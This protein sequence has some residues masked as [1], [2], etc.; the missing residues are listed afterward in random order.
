M[1]EVEAAVLSEV[2]LNPSRVEKVVDELLHRRDVYLRM[3][4]KKGRGG[5]LACR[6]PVPN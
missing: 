3:A 5:A 4:E 2:G 1:V 6:H